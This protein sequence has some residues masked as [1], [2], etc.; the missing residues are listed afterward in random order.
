[1]R[2]WNSLNADDV[3][4]S[5]TVFTLP[6]RNWNTGVI[7]YIKTNI[8]KFLLYL[9]G[10]ETFNRLRCKFYPAS[11]FYFTYEELKQDILEN[12]LK[13]ECSFYFTYEELKPPAKVCK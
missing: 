3:L 12:A 11:S 2:N 7:D 5:S 6:M 8:D 1:M 9:W 10:I 4:H 13:D